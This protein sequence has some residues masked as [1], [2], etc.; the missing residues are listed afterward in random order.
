MPGAAAPPS[1]RA[2]ASSCSRFGERLLGRDTVVIVASDGL[3][4]GEPDTA[5]RRDARRCARR[6]AAL[7]W[8]NPL[9]DTAGYEPTAAGMSA[10][11]PHISTFASVESLADFA[12]LSRV[13]RL[14]G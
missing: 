14:R 4:V 1:A 11:R 6:S 7:V 9:L 5:S 3:D 8:L 10:A 13:V 2:C 12:R